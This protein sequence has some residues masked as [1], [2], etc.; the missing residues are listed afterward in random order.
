MAAAQVAAAQVAA[1]QVAA[2]Q[3]AAAQVAA[4]QV[5]DVSARSTLQQNV[6]IIRGPCYAWP[7]IHP[8]NQASQV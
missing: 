4:A 2:A 1:A 3:V 6:T 7:V 8:E 5:A